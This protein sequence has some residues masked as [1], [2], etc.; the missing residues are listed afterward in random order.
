M[1]QRFIERFAPQFLMEEGRKDAPDRDRIKGVADAFSDS[2]GHPGI[3]L[4]ETMQNV[5]RGVNVMFNDQTGD[6]IQLLQGAGVQFSALISSVAR[7]V[8]KQYEPGIVAKIVSEL[9]ETGIEVISKVPGSGMLVKDGFDSIGESIAQELFEIIQNDE[10]EDPRRF[11]D[12]EAA[13]DYVISTFRGHL[14]GLIL[15]AMRQMEEQAVSYGSDPKEIGRRRT[16]AER[17]FRDSADS[18][19]RRN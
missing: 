9:A 16:L 12:A 10:L 1:F 17:A 8:A 18:I 11:R 4:K 2:G 15:D 6:G 3:L 13:R 5:F 7:H 19:R 14:L